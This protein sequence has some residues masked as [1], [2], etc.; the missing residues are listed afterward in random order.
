MII[1]VDVGSANTIVASLNKNGEIINHIKMATPNSAT[2][3]TDVI[4]AAIASQFSKLNFDQIIVGV[5]GPVKD[6]RVAWCSNLDDNWD[7]FDLAGALQ[8]TFEVPVTL[9]NDANLAGLAE[10]D[11]L[12]QTPRSAVYLSIGAG[13]GSSIIIDG[14]LVKG[15]LNSEAGMTELEYDGKIRTWESFASGKA[16]YEAY[17]KLAEEITSRRIWQAIT[18]RIARGL[19]VLVPIIQPEL[20]IIGGSMGMS[21]SK[22]GPLLND[23]LDEKLPI[24]LDRPRIIAASQPDLAVIYGIGIYE[25]TILRKQS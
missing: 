9:E 2:D 16:I 3:A 12:A 1:A 8:S 13:I 18:D 23:L 21:F 4:T 6:N 22:Y 17:D 7:N 11:A 25:R 14:K 15:L 20:I 24:K 10:V 19:L 5:P